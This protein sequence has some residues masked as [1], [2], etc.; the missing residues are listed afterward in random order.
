MLSAV[1]KDIVDDIS[2]ATAVEYGLVVTLIVI[3]MLAALQG[4]ADTVVRMWDI[5]ET[6]SVDAMTN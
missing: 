1:L 5:V 6:R 3:G 4:T 2:G